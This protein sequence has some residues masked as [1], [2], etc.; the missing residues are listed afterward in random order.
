MTPIPSTTPQPPTML[1]MNALKHPF[2]IITPHRSLACSFIQEA[3]A[4][5]GC[6]GVKKVFKAPH[7]PHVGRMCVW[8]LLYESIDVRVV[9]D[10]MPGCDSPNLEIWLQKECCDWLR[11]CASAQTRKWPY[12]LY[13]V[14]TRGTVVSDPLHG[15]V[16]HAMW[17]RIMTFNNESDS[18][19]PTEKE[20]NQSTKSTSKP[21]SHG[22][23]INA[24]VN[25]NQNPTDEM[26]NFIASAHAPHTVLVSY[27]LSS[28]IH[29]LIPVPRM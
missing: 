20:K 15:W 14:T 18:L 24:P 28:A 1:Q 10:N 4:R 25:Q 23:A 12:L 8:W 3:A 6:V 7:L 22:Y 29:P 27:G 19:L 11:L 9:F 21:Y 5:V 16:S 13:A 17:Y 26:R 2:I